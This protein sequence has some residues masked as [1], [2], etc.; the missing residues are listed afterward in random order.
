VVVQ[1]VID[2]IFKVVVEE[3]LVV[4]EKVEIIL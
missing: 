2:I 3:E 4:L 1:V